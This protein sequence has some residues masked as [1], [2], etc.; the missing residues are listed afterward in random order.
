MDVTFSK[1]DLDGNMITD[2]SANL[3]V[4]C[5]VSSI[6]RNAIAVS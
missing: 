3:S 1:C 5:G 6:V 2:G 4:A